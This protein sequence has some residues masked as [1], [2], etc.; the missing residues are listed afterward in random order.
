MLATN[1]MEGFVMRMKT[2]S[3]LTSIIRLATVFAITITGVE[4][5]HGAHRVEEHYVSLMAKQAKLHSEEKANLEAQLIQ[6]EQLA[7]RELDAIKLEAGGSGAN[8]PLPVR[9]GKLRKQADTANTLGEKLSYLQ[10]DTLV[11]KIEAL[12]KT[13]KD[14]EDANERLTQQYVEAQ[15]NIVELQNE[16]GLSAGDTPVQVRAR[17]LSDSV[18]QNAN[19]L[20]EAVST[21]AQELYNVSGND[22][23][24]KISSL[25]KELDCKTNALVEAQKVIVEKEEAHADLYIQHLGAQN[26]LQELDAELSVVQVKNLENQERL[27]YVLRKQFQS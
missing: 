27:L 17:K 22:L 24:E 5:V 11:E 7:Q 25:K 21:L 2:K 3:K 6:K 8:P 1:L 9:I 10:G 16:V 15:H 18:N 23:L 12:E 20:P 19:D 26:A 4:K 13:L 14:T